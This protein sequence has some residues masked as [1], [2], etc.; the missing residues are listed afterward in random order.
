MAVQLNL[1]YPLELARVLILQNDFDCLEGARS[2][3]ILKFVAARERPCVCVCVCT[4]CALC[5]CLLDALHFPV[6]RY[7]IATR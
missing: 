5:R 4:L 7:T 2:D 3:G 1:L 6:V